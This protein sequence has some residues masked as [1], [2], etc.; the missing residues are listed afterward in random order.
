[1][2]RLAAAAFL[3]LAL[4]AL[5]QTPETAPDR[6]VPFAGPTTPEN[7]AEARRLLAEGLAHN[8]ALLKEMGAPTDQ[9]VEAMVAVWPDGR[10]MLL[11]T[12]HHNTAA[13][14]GQSGAG[15]FL[16]AAAPG[17]EWEPQYSGPSFN[18]WLDAQAP[19]RDGWP[20]VI[21]QHIQGGF[22]IPYARWSWAGDRY[23]FAGE[24][25]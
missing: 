23:D 19:G 25:R 6:F 10:R 9:H 13:V 16:F 18:V 22:D 7:E 2:I 5:A 20:D 11:A 15:A 1:M 8:E 3:A 24:L 21:L 4:P 12:I 14:Y 17:G